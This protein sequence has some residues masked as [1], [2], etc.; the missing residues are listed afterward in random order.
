MYCGGFLARRTALA[1]GSEVVLEITRKFCLIVKELDA[2]KEV[3][4]NL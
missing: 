2:T 4:T 1:E 3:T